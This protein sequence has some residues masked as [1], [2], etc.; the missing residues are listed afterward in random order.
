M[1]PV[2]EGYFERHHIL[3]KSLGG[4][5]SKDN[6]V[7]LT[8]KEHYICHL[9]LMRMTTGKAQLSMIRA[10][11][12]FK[13]ASRKNPRHL[14]SRRYEFARTHSIGKGN[15]TP[16]SAETKAKISAKRKGSKSFMKDKH[17]EG[18]A[19]QNIIAATRSEERCTKISQ[20]LKGRVS[21]TKGMTHKKS[22]C[23]HCHR[24][25]APNQMARNHGDRCKFKP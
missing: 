14:N 1:N 4:T 6:L 9:L 16:M 13:M 5:N 8:P 23:P 3:P 18:Q 10:F 22:P 11:N 25:V 17:F 2:T 15:G 12:A 7:F 19:L 20:A 21:P 24:D